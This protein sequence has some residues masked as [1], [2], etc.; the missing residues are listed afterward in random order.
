MDN[1]KI[2]EFVDYLKNLKFQKSVEKK[3][4]DDKRDEYVQK[5]DA[6]ANEIENI[7]KTLEILKNQLGMPDVLKTVEGIL[8][9]PTAGRKADPRSELVLK[10]LNEKN[11]LMT[12]G[13]LEE[14]MLLITKD[15]RN[16]RHVLRGLFKSKR[17]ISVR[18]NNSLRSTFVGLPGWTE[19]IGDE[20]VLNEEFSPGLD[21]LPKVIKET[22]ITFNEKEEVKGY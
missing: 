11:H 6:T 1:R 8:S 14:E 18:Y 12:R 5:S 22:I 2:K 3:G 9:K 20:M 10:I 19:L 13:E 15:N 4:Y 7:D 17:A 21:K 16:I